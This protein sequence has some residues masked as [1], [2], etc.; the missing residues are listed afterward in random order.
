MAQLPRHRPEHKVKR[1]E[2]KNGT[3]II[4][5]TTKEMREIAAECRRAGCDRQLTPAQFKLL[6]PYPS[7][8]WHVISPGMFSR[9]D[10]LHIACNLFLKLIGTSNV[11]RTII[12]VPSECFEEVLI[13]EDLL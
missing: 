6:D 1:V 11:V 5:A 7:L 13:S 4:R 12:D 10:K 2:T 9:G 8:K 3:I